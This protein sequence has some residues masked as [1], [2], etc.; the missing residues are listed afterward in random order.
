MTSMIF[1][2]P[3]HA[4]VSEPTSL[5]QTRLILVLF[6]VYVIGAHLRLSLYSGG[7]IL[8]PMYLMLFSS[9]V[10]AIWFSATLWKTSGLKFCALLGFVLFQ[11]FLGGGESGFGGAILSVVQLVASMVGA[12]AMMFALGK[13]DSAQTRKLIF[14]IW[15]V[16]IALAFMESFFLKALFDQ[17]R[18][19]IYSETGRGVYI[20][21]DRDLEIY[22]RVRT[23][24]FAS[25]P[26]F[27]ADTL[28]SLSVM[29]FMLTNKSGKLA[30]WALLGA[31]LIVSF[32]VAPSFKM[33]FYLIGVVIW[34][35]WPRSFTN[36]LLLLIFLGIGLAVVTSNA[37]S[38]FALLDSVLGGHSSTGSFFGRIGSAPLVGIEALS[39]FPLFGF[40]IGNDDDVYSIIV[41]VWH[42]T[43]AF[44][45]FPWYGSLGASD[46]L[47]NGFWWMVTYLGIVGTAI[48]L[49]L[50]AR[51]LRGVGVLTPWRSLV[52][53]SV[54]WY[55]GSAFIDPQSWFTILVF[56][57]GALSHKTPTETARL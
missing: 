15:I 40:G 14:T 33:S 8:V 32:F 37:D 5:K 24:V 27:L 36:L 57:I 48:F 11:P 49:T 3:G 19:L 9:A 34:Q 21:V 23:T 46:L 41:E 43:G 54:V 45:L 55:A 56:S 38:I 17:A 7:S 39:K 35:F 47:S 28:S 42:Q 16:F 29:V 25:E 6:L 20:A 31:M 50:S 1:Q 4:S 30:S 26:S 2:Q 51:L 13:V 52:C 22:G 44:I 53:G 10:V 18:A 12:L